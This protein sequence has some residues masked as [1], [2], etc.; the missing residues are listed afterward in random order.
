MAEKPC[1]FCE[2]SGKYPIFDQHGKQRYSIGCPECCGEGHDF[3]EADE[4]AAE[5]AEKQA[6]IVQQKK[7]LSTGGHI[8]RQ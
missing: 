8:H 3:G 4:L 5:Q 7:Y 1:E 6:V 2:G